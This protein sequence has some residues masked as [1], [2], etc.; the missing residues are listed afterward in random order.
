MPSD[1]S[2]AALESMRLQNGYALAVDTRDWAY[3]RTLFTPDVRARY[4]HGEFNGMDEWLG[5]FIPFHHTCGWTS[6]VITNHVVGQDE[7]GIWGTCY[8]LVQWTVRDQPGL[9]NRATVLFRDRLVSDG[10]Q[11]RVARRKLSL[12]MDEIGAPVAAGV[13]LRR[14][15]L[16]LADWS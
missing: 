8:G 12:L 16:D 1:L 3:F 13:V 9:I 6:H 11:W 15:V 7:H 4:P 2:R 5:N 14:S 10:G